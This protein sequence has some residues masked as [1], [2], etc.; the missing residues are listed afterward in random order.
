MDTNKV[1]NVIMLDTYKVPD[2][3]M[4]DTDKGRTMR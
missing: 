1:F 3:I 2:T 4:L